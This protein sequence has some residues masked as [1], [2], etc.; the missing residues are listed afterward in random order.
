[1]RSET[2]RSDV[3]VE[4]E[5]ESE[6]YLT[7]LSEIVGEQVKLDDVTSIWNIAEAER[8]HNQPTLKE[9]ND[10]DIQSFLSETSDFVVSKKISIQAIHKLI[11]H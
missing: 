2:K 5:K 8:V 7:A 9:L 10:H 3:W 11:L 4:K 6:K 1:M